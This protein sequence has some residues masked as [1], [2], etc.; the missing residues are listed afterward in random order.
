MNAKFLTMDEELLT[1][2]QLRRLVSDAVLSAERSFRIGA[3]DTEKLS[4]QLLQRL[5][6]HWRE[7]ILI[8]VRGQLA[9]F[10][11]FY[12][13]GG[14]MMLQDLYVFPE[15]RCGGLGTA[16]LRHCISCTELPVCSDIFDADMFMQ[17]LFR[18]AG[19]RRETSISP[20]I[21]RW[22]YDNCEPF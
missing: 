5:K 8:R 14:I 12:R 19:F 13:D 21:S 18:N 4:S 10:C 20:S 6:A 2:E 16:V 3:A 22:V 1:R 11:C 17:S 9:G 15:Y 7:Y